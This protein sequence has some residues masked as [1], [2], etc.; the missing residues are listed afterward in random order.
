MDLVD[1][2]LDIATL[3]NCLVKGGFV[4]KVGVYDLWH[5]RC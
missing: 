3:L 4:F 5:G 1:L 2:Y